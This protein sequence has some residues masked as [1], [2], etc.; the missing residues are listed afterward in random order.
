MLLKFMLHL[1]QFIVVAGCQHPYLLGFVL[2]VLHRAHLIRVMGWLFEHGERHDLRWYRRKSTCVV[3][4]CTAVEVLA[5][6][7]LLILVRGEMLGVE[8]PETDVKCSRSV[9]DRATMHVSGGDHLLVS[10]ADA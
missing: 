6:L 2:S 7:L 10:D 4:E 5:E 3:A 8:V 9:A 1:G